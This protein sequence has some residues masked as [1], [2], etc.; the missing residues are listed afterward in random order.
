MPSL[1]V[2][3]GCFEVERLSAFRWRVRNTLT[4]I[5]HVTYGSEA[6]VVEQLELQTAA[7]RKRFE[8]GE[9]RMRKGNFRGPAGKP[10]ARAVAT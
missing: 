7:W 3:I 9:G 1:P 6:E 5:V 2:L 4:E 8:T 10:K